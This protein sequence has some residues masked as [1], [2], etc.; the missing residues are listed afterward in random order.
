MV[1]GSVKLQTRAGKLY[2]NHCIYAPSGALLFRC[3]DKKL[4]WYIDRNLAIE[5]TSAPLDASRSATLTFEPKG[6]GRA[7]EGDEWYL[8]TQ[9]DRCVVCGSTAGLI[10]LH[11]VP[12]QYRNALPLRYKSHSNHDILP[13]CTACTV[14]YEGHVLAMRRM[15]EK[16]YNAP[17]HGRG[18]QKVQDATRVKSAAAALLRGFA[19]IP[20]VRR[21]A[22]R[23]IVA[24]YFDVAAE[25][26]TVMQL[27]EAKACPLVIKTAE[28]IDHGTLVVQGVLYESGDAGAAE[29]VREWRRLFLETMRPRYLLE[30]WRV[31]DPVMN[32]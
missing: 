23:E 31:E 13:F 15:L 27:E 25:E 4:Q 1:D 19:L 8:A 10:L 32:A 20:E 2:S 30:M 28:F 21:Q 26:V 7:R 6:P 24:R 9:Q 29:F 11:I 3:S 17:L 16:R 5:T 22:L 14:R 18:I 12:A